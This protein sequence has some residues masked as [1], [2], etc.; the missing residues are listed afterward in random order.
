[1][2]NKELI[3]QYFELPKYHWRVYVHYNV[4]ENSE[5]SF[6]S[7][8]QCLGVRKKTYEEAY[9]RIVFSDLGKGLCYSNF[10]RKASALIFPNTRSSKEFIQCLRH[11]IMELSKHIRLVYSIDTNSEEAHTLSGDISE[12]MFEKAEWLI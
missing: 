7:L 4:N 5:E 8:L 10:R 3:V 6:L 2:E 9:K 11:E 1:M 12:Y